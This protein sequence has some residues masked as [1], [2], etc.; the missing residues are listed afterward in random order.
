MMLPL[1]LGNV[2]AYCVQ[3]AVL[4]LVGAALVTLLRVRTPAARLVCWRALLAACLGL[5]LL[6]PWGEPPSHTAAAVASVIDGAALATTAARGEAW[7]VAIGWAPLLLAVWLAGTAVWL[8]RLIIGLVHLRAL[9][10]AGAPASLSPAV[11]EVGE[12]IGA[13]ADIRWVAGIPQ[14]VTFGMRHPVVLL[15][16]A[17]HGMSTEVQR[18]VVAHELIHVIRRDWVWVLAEELVRAVLW[19]HPAIWWLLGR[20]Q[21]A[22][23]QVVDAYAVRVLGAR[24]PYME[25]LLACADRTSFVPVPAFARRRELF[26]R[27]T[28]LSREVEMSRARVLVSFAA[29][30]L[31]V[32]CAERYT[33]AAF[34]L[35]A[36]SP[37][38]G[39]EQASSKDEAQGLRKIVHVDPQY[40]PHVSLDDVRGVVTLN[41][42]VD[43]RGSVIDAQVASAKIIE[44]ASAEGQSHVP[45]E[46]AEAVRTAALQWKYEP[47]PQPMATVV[48][49]AFGKGTD[50]PVSPG[51]ES[52]LPSHIQ[53]GEPEGKLRM[54]YDVERD[55]D[56]R[57]VVIQPRLQ[58][59]TEP[60]AG[61]GGVADPRKPL[62]IGGAIKQPRRIHNVDPIYPAEAQAARVQ[63]I[64]I[65][66]TIVGTDG[67]VTDARTLESVPMLDQAAR[68]AVLQWT[69]TPTIVNGVA[70]P[71]IVTVTVNFTLR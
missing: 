53:A 58:V 52:S 4:T 2:W 17:L 22:R 3:V 34:P 47:L 68:D 55:N 41:I 49:V 32:I 62:R 59:R 54:V 15:P 31:G 21:L 56:N 66:E 16:A 23:E 26:Q 12:Q 44:G 64:V 70:V 43:E 33:V 28:Q 51:D 45:G 11:A 42:T 13:S 39:T 20:T 18:A 67:T 7:W 38:G 8:V 57:Q 37:A 61:T 19:F 14:P 35:H 40:P 48:S 30:A 65:L 69:Y 5:P 36:A 63:G 9:R 29:L 24:R 60:P 10:R 46:V 1:S 27:L 71:V 50:R 6:Q 25:A